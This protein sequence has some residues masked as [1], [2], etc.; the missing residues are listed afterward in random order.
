MRDAQGEVSGSGVPMLCD[1]TMP[2]I[3]GTLRKVY[4]MP[5]AFFIF[6]FFRK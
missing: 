2:G 4:K 6:I 1:M 3:T 5:K